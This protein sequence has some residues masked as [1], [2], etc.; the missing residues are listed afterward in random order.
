[1]KIATQFIACSLLTL[2]ACDPK[3]S[4]QSPDQAVDGDQSVTSEQSADASAPQVSLIQSSTLP[5][6]P[7]PVTSFG[8]ID[9]G[10]KVYVLGGYSGKPHAYSREGQSG[11]FYEYSTKDKSWK[12]LPGINPLQS[13]TLDRFGD[14]LIRIGGM[15]AENA[16]GEKSR[17]HSVD[18]VEFFDVGAGKWSKG[19]ALPEPRSSHDATT[20]GDE[21]VVVGGWNLEEGQRSGTWLESTLVL[22]AGEEGAEWKT[23]PQPF[24]RRALALAAA[25]RKVYAIGGM[26]ERG[27]SASVEVLDLDTG[28]WSKGPELPAPAFGAAAVST[29]DGILVN[30]MD[31]VVYRLNP[32]SQSWEEYDRLLFPRFFHRLV[33]NEGQVWAIGGIHGMTEEDRIA[34]VEAL[35]P[36]NSKVESYHW[37]LDWSGAAKNRQAIIVDRDSLFLMGGNNSLGQHDFAAENFVGESK[38]VHLTS[39]RVSDHSELPQARQSLVVLEGEG[40]TWKLIGGFGWDG[41]VARTQDEAYIGQMGKEGKVVWEKQEAA[42]PVPLSQF[43]IVRSED[44]VRL[45]GGLDY[46]PRRDKKEHF[47]HNDVVMA[48]D[49]KQF[50]ATKE[51][52]G[53]RRAFASAEAGGFYYVVGGMKENFQR[54]DSCGRFPV[55]N[56]E[57]WEDI[58]CPRNPGLGA[59]LVSVDDQILLVRGRIAVKEKEE[60]LPAVA[61]YNAKTKEWDTVMESHPLPLTHLHAL[62]HGGNLLLLS[63][64]FES[65]KMEILLVQLPKK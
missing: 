39:M 19:P 16:A 1:M 55:N 18:E 7:R 61:A 41:E 54:V 21:V 56:P 28:K 38:E 42:L 17:I 62:E 49:G 48:Y 20:A 6:M 58:P 5:S 11:E 53:P 30:S 26:D 13:V 60:K 45:I 3:A 37:A 34:H 63:T 43:K 10:D 44:E 40:S 24:H 64:H 22:K 31:G 52:F 46:D 57:K 32:T 4:T 25:G 59:K 51:K 23:I 2:M 12:A 36:D 33:E 50:A 47:L 65:P 15:R 9:Q 14:K 8:G 27:P 29:K 35:S